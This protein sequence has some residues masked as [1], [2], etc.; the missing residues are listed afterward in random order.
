MQRQIWKA[1]GKD[2][3]VGKEKV[4][5][6]LNLWPSI[7]ATY[8]D[9]SEI[10]STGLRVISRAAYVVAWFAKKTKTKKTHELRID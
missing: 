1:K 4:E 3:K 8:I 10:S 2:A 7:Q 6:M 9:A 5:I